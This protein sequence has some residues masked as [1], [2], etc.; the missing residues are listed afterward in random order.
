LRTTFVLFKVES[1]DIQG[2]VMRSMSLRAFAVAVLVALTT[3][4]CGGKAVSHSSNPKVLVET[5]QGNFTAELFSDVT[6]TTENFTTLVKSGFYNGLTF[7]RYVQGFVIQG[8]DPTGT[9]SGG[10]GKTIPLEIVKEHQHVKGALGM[11]RSQDP[12]S[13]SCQFYVCLEDVHQLDGNYCVFG[14]V[15]EGMENVE[16]LRQGDKMTKV[17]LLED[18]AK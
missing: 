13:A 14:K 11:A 12:D 16:K 3:M 4:G 17:T 5:T 7:H 8:G 15:L 10:S 6:K 1:F 9:G 18:A 2:D